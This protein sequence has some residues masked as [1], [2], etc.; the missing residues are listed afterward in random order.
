M[1]IEL[2][3]PIYQS[4]KRFAAAAT[5]IALQRDT[6]SWAEPTFFSQFNGSAG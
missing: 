6:T 5:A 2:P 1:W 3:D 4:L